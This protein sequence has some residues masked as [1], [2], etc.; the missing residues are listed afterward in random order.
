LQIK[1]VGGLTGLTGSGDVVVVFVPIPENT[2]V[3]SDT[4]AAKPHRGGMKWKADAAA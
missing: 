3:G 4:R 1:G 2:G